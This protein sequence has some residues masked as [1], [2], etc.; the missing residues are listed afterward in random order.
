MV[1]DLNSIFFLF[2]DHTPRTV[3]YNYSLPFYIIVPFLSIKPIP[4]TAF[5]YITFTQLQHSNGYNPVH[6]LSPVYNNP[7]VHYHLHPTV[8]F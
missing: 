6:S 5:Q 2:S 8:I 1:P 3:L 4:I 7:P